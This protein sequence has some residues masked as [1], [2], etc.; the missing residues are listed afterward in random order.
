MRL[1]RSLRRLLAAAVLAATAPAALPGA[2]A[3][4]TENPWLARRVLNIAH[5]GGADEWPEH[6]LF[7]YA[8]A[9]NAGADVLELDVHATADGAIV[10]IHDGTL[11]RTT[12]TPERV[13]SKT[14]AEVKAL[15]A[16]CRWDDYRGI[17][18]G[19]RAPPPGYTANDFRVPTLDEVLARFPDALVNIE[20]K[21]TFAAGSASEAVVPARVAEILGERVRGEDTIV[22]AFQDHAVEAFRAAAA[23]HAPDVGVATATGRAAAFWASAQGDGPG[24]PSPGSVALQVP[25][26]FQGVTVLTADFVADAHA[27]GLAVH[28]WDVEGAALWTQAISQW[29][30]D[31]IMT[32]RPT[33]LQALLCDLGVAWDQATDCP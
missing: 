26:T 19:E 1:R 4:V 23:V 15:D 13:D 21:H 14:L 33:D 12:C 25:P 20:I 17:A 10:V 3:I 6:T 32:D 9:R 11:D 31:G 16:A 18:T 29:G 5:R 27:N 2:A 7:A 30:V 24:A 22:V 8:E 28:A